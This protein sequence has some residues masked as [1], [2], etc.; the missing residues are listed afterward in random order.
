[1]CE[2]LLYDRGR[3]KDK[4]PRTKKILPQICK[5]CGTKLS[6]KERMGIYCLLCYV[7]VNENL[8][9]Y[10]NEFITAKT[11]TSIIKIDTKDFNKR[12]MLIVLYPEYSEFYT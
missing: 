1:M 9:S 7:L 2:N 6:S 3:Q 5:V 4:S 11:N 8:I 12:D 10:D